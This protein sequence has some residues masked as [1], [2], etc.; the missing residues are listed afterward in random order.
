MIIQSK[1]RNFKDIIIEKLKVTKNL[2]EFNWGD[3]VNALNN[4]EG[5]GFWL[6]DLPNVDGFNDLPEFKHEGKLVK[7]CAIVTYEFYVEDK[8]VDVLYT[9]DERHA[10]R[11]LTIHS[12]EELNSILGDELSSKIY[13]IIS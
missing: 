8:L 4:C 1:M 11:A 2:G 13:R 12:L 3:F 7:V 9:D 6:E 10:R 5:I